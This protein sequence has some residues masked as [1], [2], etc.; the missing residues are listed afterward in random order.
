MHFKERNIW[1]ILVHLRFGGLPKRNNNLHTGSI[2]SLLSS[3]VSDLLRL[4]SGWLACQNC[5]FVSHSRGASSISLWIWVI[6]FIITRDGGQWVLWPA[7]GCMIRPQR[8]RGIK[9][10]AFGDVVGG[11]VVVDDCLSKREC[12]QSCYGDH[13]WGGHHGV[14]DEGE[15]VS[16]VTVGSAG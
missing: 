8:R 9:G 16:N 10:Y 15:A 12:R 11:G 14:E 2:F 1:F 5:G 6:Q 7:V 4:L 13:R 3:L